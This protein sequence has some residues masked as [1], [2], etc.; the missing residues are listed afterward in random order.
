MHLSAACAGQSHSP[1]VVTL[2]QVDTCHSHKCPFPWEDMDPNLIHGSLDPHESAPKDI[3]ISSARF[4]TAHPR[5]QQT[6][7]HTETQN[8]LRVTS[9]A[10]GRIYALHADK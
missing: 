3:F 6:D 8:K 7:K 10:T 9:V 5:A 4:C 2:L 1:R